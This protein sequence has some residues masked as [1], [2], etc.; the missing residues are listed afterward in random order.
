MGRIIKTCPEC[1]SSD[2][3]MRSGRQI[4]PSPSDDKRWICVDCGWS[5]DDPEEREADSGGWTAE[6]VL[7]QFRGAS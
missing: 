5:F 6:R 7:E 4:G 3:R 2:I 1:S